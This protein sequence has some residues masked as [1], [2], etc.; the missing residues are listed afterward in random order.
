MARC[1]PVLQSQAEYIAVLEQSISELKGKL[2]D[3][4]KRL[5]ERSAEKQLQNGDNQQFSIHQNF[6]QL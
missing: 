1:S 4:E 3:S 6:K 5:L 2:R